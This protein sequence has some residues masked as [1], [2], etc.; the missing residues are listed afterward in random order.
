[1][2]LYVESAFSRHFQPAFRHDADNFRLH[3]QRDGD[4]LRRIGHFQIQARGNFFSQFR[5]IAVLDV[6]PILAQMRRDAV[7]AGRLRCERGLH[8]TRL[9]AAKP[10]ITRLANGRDMVNVDAEFQHDSM[11]RSRQHRRIIFP[12]FFQAVG[13]RRQ[14]QVAAGKIFCI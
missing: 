6:P 4:D 10:A 12:K 7:R 3:L 14:L 11:G 8:G 2:F 13:R 9:A 5:H 1:M